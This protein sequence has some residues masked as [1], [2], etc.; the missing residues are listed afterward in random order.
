MLYAGAAVL[1]V[2]LQ[3][4]VY[5]SF[6]HND[7]VALTSALIM[8]SALDAVVLVRTKADVD[9]HARTPWE[10]VLERLWAILI[11]NFIFTFMTMSGLGLLLA[12]DIITRLL[13]MLTL[14]FAIAMV[15]AEAIAAVGDEERW[16]F[17]V[18]AA[19]GESIRT[20]WRGSN[21]W[22]AGAL[23]AA[24]LLPVA[25]GNALQPLLTLHHVPDA[26]F[27]SNVP[28]GILLAIPLDVVIVLAY[29]QMTG[30]EPK[31]PCGE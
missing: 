6:P 15:F 5:R 21:L 11:V 18:I 23:F 14:L 25:L 31:L 13:G 28:V 8:G 1:V 10:H 20:A 7:A 27:W 24:Q 26:S 4:Y 17:L 2:G 29:L 9:G 12:S 19:V 3:W 30:Y 16:W 22:F